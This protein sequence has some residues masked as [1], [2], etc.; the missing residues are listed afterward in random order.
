MTYDNATGTVLLFGGFNGAASLYNDTWTW[1]G[2]TWIQQ[3]PA[4]VPAARQQ[5]MVAYDAILGSVVLFGGSNGPGGEFSDTWAWNGTNWV[6]L[7]PATAPAGRWV[8]GMA[9]DPP[10]RSLMLF[11]GF[12][13]DT[14]D[15]TWLFTLVP[16]NGADEK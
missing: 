13:T 3:F 12:G 9:Y 7:H 10:D 6:E 15:D 8:A 2:T 4:S 5:G 1:D 14:L 11:A 16:V